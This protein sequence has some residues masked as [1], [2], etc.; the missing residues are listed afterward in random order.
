MLT[1][2]KVNGFKN[3]L[4][5]DVRFGPFTCI[6][7]A[8]GVGKSNLFDAIAFLSALAERPLVDAALSVRVEGGRASDIKG[9]FHRFGDE[10]ANQMSFEADMIVPSDGVDDLGQD[11]HASITFLR[12]R[13]TLAHRLDDSLR[14]P[15]SLEIVEEELRH[16]NIGDAYRELQFP[17]SRD[18]RKSVIM[19]RRGTPFISMIDEPGH[20]RQVRLHQEG[21]QGRTLN[22]LAAALPRT[23]LS[24]TN[25]AESPTVQLAQQEMRSWRLLQLEPSAMRKPDDFAAPTRLGPDGAHL[26]ATLFSLGRSA[27]QATDVGIAGEVAVYARVANRL[28]E[29][30]DDVRDIS[31]DRDEKRELLTLVVTGRD[32]TTHPARAL[33]DGTLRFL[34]LA[35]L[36]E[37]PETPGLLCLEEPENGIH[38][39]RIPAM[40]HLLQDIATDVDAP[41][42]SDNPLRQV[43]VNTHS[44][45]VV[46]QV[47]ED[48]LIVA[49]LRETVQNGRRFKRVHFTG[50]PGTWRQSK[51]S[52][53]AVSLGM[54]LAYLSPDE[55]RASPASNGSA[56]ATPSRRVMD[57]PDIRQLVLPT[58]TDA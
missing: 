55:P 24:V 28:A 42:G 11:A 13:L 58:Y 54:L 5:V 12:Y 47:P 7:G 41:V 43:I 44:P 51:D 26:A 15:S 46:R 1:R 49:E 53:A 29:L 27:S 23:V 33:S 21:H 38:P 2:L 3:L 45:S 30:I 40:L 25:A 36:Q 37:Q 56:K 19:G 32:G 31:I 4:D 9:L 34:A 35:V 10:Y 48:S 50:L 20:R 6:A 16:I 8:N 57:R 22:R 52:Q 17:N 14:G 18:W 39:A